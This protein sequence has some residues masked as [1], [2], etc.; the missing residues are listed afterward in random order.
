MYSVLVF[1]DKMFFVTSLNCSANVVLESKLSKSKFGGAT[2]KLKVTMVYSVLPQIEPA[3][4]SGGMP[5][6]PVGYAVPA[7]Q[8]PAYIES[9]RLC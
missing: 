3:L 8:P 4:E 9:G 2:M 7:H 5:A 6:S 1:Y